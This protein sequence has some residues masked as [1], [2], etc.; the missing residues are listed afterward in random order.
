MDHLDLLIFLAVAAELSITRAA[1]HLGRVP[2]NVSTRVQ[3]LE[4]ELGV[5]LFRRDGKRLS[6]T[7]AGVCFRGYALRMT[8]L[9]DELRQQLHPEGPTGSFRLGSMES[10][11]ASRLP[12]PLARFHQAWPQVRLSVRTG[13]S[14]PL[15]DAVRDNLLDAALVALPPSSERQARALLAAQGLMGQAVF[16]EDLLLLLPPG[17]GPVRRAADVAVPSLAAFDAGCT[18]RAILE[19]WLEGAPARPLIQVVGSYHAMLAC[20]ASGAA[21]CLMPRSV[22]DLL[23]PPPG[24]VA[25]AMGEVRTWLVW[26][27]ASDTPACQ[28]WRQLLAPVTPIKGARGSRR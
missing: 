24:L 4:R 19:D 9:T 6:L 23:K 20:V 12:E 26:R 13:P 15:L 11:A 3:Q 7:D 10:T 22:L 8:A 21:A 14:G 27:I 25:H 28:A 18:Y 2:S 1:R 16:K 5:A 17:H